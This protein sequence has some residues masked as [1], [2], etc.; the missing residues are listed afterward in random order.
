MKAFPNPPDAVL[1]VGAAVMCLMPPGGK[2]PRPAQRD[3]KACKANMGNVDAF[4]RKSFISSIIF[5][6]K[7]FKSRFDILLPESLK[8]YDKEHIRD[9]MRREAK[10]YVEDPEFDPDKIRSKS[11][12]AAGLCAWVINILL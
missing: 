2:I 6:G 1:K 5:N 10:V 4:L 9:D 11:M 7:E 12:A 3:W 8:T